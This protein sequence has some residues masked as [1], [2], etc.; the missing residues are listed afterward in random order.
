MIK[1]S[2]HLST[3]EKRKI[4]RLLLVFQFTFPSCSEMLVVFYHSLFNTRLRLLYLFLKL[5][6]ETAAGNSNETK[7]VIEYSSTRDVALLII[8]CS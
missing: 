6:Y 1:H 8:L 2:G 4:A 5:Y 7:N 3:L